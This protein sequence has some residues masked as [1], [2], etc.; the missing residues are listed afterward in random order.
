MP[1]LKYL[2]K[3]MLAFSMLFICWI[4]QTLAQKVSVNRSHAITINESGPALANVPTTGILNVVAI[5]VEFQPD[6]N[7]LTSGTGIF[8]EGG[9]PYL[10]NNPPVIDPL[11]HDQAYFEAHLEFAKNYF[12]KSSNGQLSIQYQVLPHIY[13]LSKEMKEYSP[14][15]QTFTYEKLAELS[16]EAWELVE[17]S[18]GFDATGLDPDHT[19]FI[20][21]HAG[22]GRDI[23][24][25]GTSLEITPYDIPSIYLGKHNLGELLNTPGFAGFPVNNGAFRVT[26]SM[27]LPRTQSRRGFDIQDEEFVFPLS[28]NGLL[29]ASIGSH[30]GLPD[31][32]DT[33]TGQPAIGRFGLMD[34]ASFFSYNG[35]FPPQPSAWEKV[36]LG[37]QTPFLITAE[38]TRTIDLPAASL[39]QPQSIAKYELSAHEYFLIE[40]RHRDV[41]GT[42]VTFTIRKPDGTLVQQTLTNENTDFVY[43]LA[44]LDTVLEAG[45]LI[46]VDNL[47]FSLPGGLDIG[48]DG[49]AGTDD[50]REL[51]GGILIWHIDE[52]IIKARLSEGKGVNS[53]RSWRGVDLEEADGAQDIG[54]GIPGTIDNSASFGSAFDFWWRGNN[55]RVIT[56]S[57]S[58]IQ[59]YQNRFGPDTRPDNRSNSNAPSFFEFYDFSDNLPV[60][61]FKVRSVQPFS[62]LYQLAFAEKLDSSRNYFTPPDSYYNYYP[63]SL[64]IYESPQDTFLIVPSA[65]GVTAVQLSQPQ[66]QFLLS[67]DAVQQPMIGDAVYIAE[68]PDAQA[69][70]INVAAL[71]WNTAAQKFD[72]LWVNNIPSNKGFLSSQDGDTLFA[73]FTNRGLLAENGTEVITHSSPMQQ[74]QRIGNSYA[75]AFDGFVSFSGSSAMAD[76]IPEKSN[77]RLYTGIIQAGNDIL[78]YVLTEDKMVLLDPEKE[79]AIT[80]YEEAEAEWPLILDD[81]SILWVNKAENRIEG[82]N[83]AGGTLAN[84]PIH[85]PHGVYFE[86]T[87]LYTDLIKTETDYALL[88]LGRHEHSLNVY[89]YDAAGTLIEGFPLYVGEIEDTNARALHPLI[90]KSHLYAVGHKGT[91]KAW[92][93]AQVTDTKWAGRYGNA[94]FNKVSAFVKN[95]QPSAEQHYKVLNAE[96]T[97]N[98]PNPARDET[99]IRFEI[100]P[101]GGKVEITIITLNGRVIFRE[102]V[103]SSG[104]FPEEISVNTRHWASGGYIALVKATVENKTETKLIKIGV[105][106]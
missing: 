81:A 83:R 77:G 26:N 71:H 66:N 93:L 51:N 62:H 18:G 47:D 94:P 79:T 14:V 45:V 65:D 43:Q 53:N 67:Q 73:D 8:G 11:P 70:E 42:G 4:P 56:Q 95:T 39:N 31:L 72:S 91:L 52:S 24:L 74:S 84:F 68:K 103:Q 99:H 85:A 37:W 78:F 60:A 98:W 6:S 27:I 54:P 19:A 102:Q 63:L 2:L 35:L 64:S 104:G 58:S 89:A 38:E 80:I 90:Y 59:F 46:D 3:S 10:E 49:K 29:V 100:A 92:N 106:H 50:D 20:I 16:R 30:L 28:I 5:M 101:P 87:P 41:N 75:T 23:E 57:G 21:F 69:A 9:L 105:V 1:I 86:G 36:Y 15:G 32:F 97:Y 25:T 17:A 7:R 55:Y 22:V 44:D 48:D 76:Y 33:E 34:G 82:K 61:S 88:V 13:R 12:E 96:E 40:N